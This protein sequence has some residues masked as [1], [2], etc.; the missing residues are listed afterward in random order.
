MKKIEKSN[1]E[2]KLTEILK[3]DIHYFPTVVFRIRDILAR[4]RI[5]IRGSVLRTY[6]PDSDLDPAL[7]ISDY[8]D[9]NKKYCFK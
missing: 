9:V 3:Q 1:P 6:D 5:Q 8:K 2:E 4:I 7:F